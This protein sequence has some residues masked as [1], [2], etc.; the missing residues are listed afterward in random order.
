MKLSM[1]R[2]Q[3]WFCRDDKLVEDQ[4]RARLRAERSCERITDRDRDDFAE[5]EFAE[6]GDRMEMIGWN[7]RSEGRN[8]MEMSS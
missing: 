4:L 6:R 5:T 8:E 7:C 2:D 1:Q 3:R